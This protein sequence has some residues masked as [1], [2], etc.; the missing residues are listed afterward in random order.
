M[1][2][3]KWPKKPCILNGNGYIKNCRRKKSFSK[4]SKKIG[5]P[6]QLLSEL[7]GSNIFFNYVLNEEAPF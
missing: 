2:T 7:V 4:L 5:L 6:F 1:G 3:T